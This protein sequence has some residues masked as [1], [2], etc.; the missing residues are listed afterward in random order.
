[1]E[2]HPLFLAEWHAQ[3]GGEEGIRRDQILQ[4][5]AATLKEGPSR[6][7]LQDVV[8]LTLAVDA[9]TRR[10]LTQLCCRMGYQTREEG[11]VTLLE[12]PDIVLR[13]LPETGSVRGIQEMVLRVQRAPAEGT[14]FRFG[15]QSVLSFRDDG[16]AVW[17]L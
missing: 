9:A 2:Y 13:L 3:A 4:R 10:F 17:S 5:Y 11:D 14:S 1:M 15:P 6:P 7:C 12:G 16:T 8:G